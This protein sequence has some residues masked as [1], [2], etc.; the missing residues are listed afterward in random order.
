MTSSIRVRAM[1]TQCF[2]KYGVTEVYSEDSFHPLD[3][4]VNL[5]CLMPDTS[6]ASKL[7]GMLSRCFELPSILVSSNQTDIIFR[8]KK[9]IWRKG[10]WYV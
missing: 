6:K 1:A 7:L 9:L 10:T 3:K 5:Y 4:G 8:D 2:E